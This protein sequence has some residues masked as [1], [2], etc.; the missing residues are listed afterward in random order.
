MSN[1]CT[2]SGNAFQEN[3]HLGGSLLET[4]VVPENTVLLSNY[5]LFKLCQ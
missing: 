2:A 3:R 5:G 1:L 4:D